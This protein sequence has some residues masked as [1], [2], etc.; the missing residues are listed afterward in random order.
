MKSR[1]WQECALPTRPTVCH[2]RRVYRAWCD[3]SSHRLRE[4][5]SHRA[6]E[7]HIMAGLSACLL[8]VAMPTNMLNLDWR[9]LLKR[10]PAVTNLDEVASPIR[11]RSRPVI[12]L[13]PSDRRGRPT[14]VAPHRMLWRWLGSCDLARR[15][16][17]H[18]TIRCNL[19][20]IE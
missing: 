1:F 12:R 8:L 6:T 10:H 5:V 17:D 13:P 4:K 18:E 15:R 19:Q 9:S 2:G 7:Q 16:L 3:R 20:V 14:L 11:S